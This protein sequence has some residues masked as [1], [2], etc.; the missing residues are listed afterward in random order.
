MRKGAESI[1]ALQPLK[2]VLKPK[3]ATKMQRCFE[4]L[5]VFLQ[6]SDFFVQKSLFRKKSDLHHDFY[7]IQPHRVA[8]S[9]IKSLAAARY[10][11][12]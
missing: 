3:P 5:Q 6:K 2:R 7:I 8:D 12:K 1:T 10:D 9:A 11:M 4:T